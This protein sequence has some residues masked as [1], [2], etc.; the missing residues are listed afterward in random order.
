MVLQLPPLKNFTL[1]FRGRKHK[2]APRAL[3]ID[4]FR[5]DPARTVKYHGFATTPPQKFHRCIF[6]CVIMCII[7]IYECMKVWMYVCTLWK[8]VPYHLWAKNVASGGPP[9]IF[10]KP[11]KHVGGYISCGQVKYFSEI[12]CLTPPN[13]PGLKGGMFENRS[14]TTR[15]RFL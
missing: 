1:V 13:I 10:W 12:S 2:G 8:G 6:L 9:H 15:P 5:G 4:F 14:K 3:A 11:K 7:Y